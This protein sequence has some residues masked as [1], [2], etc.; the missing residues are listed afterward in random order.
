MR[1][2]DLAELIL[3]V[4]AELGDAMNA[5]VEDDRYGYLL[6]HMQE[7]LAGMFDWPFLKLKGGDADVQIAAGARYA[8][9]PAVNLDREVTVDVQYNNY[10]KCVEYGIGPAEYNLYDSDKQQAMDPIQ[11]WQETDDIVDDG[12]G[13]RTQRFEVWPI[14]TI[15]Q[16]VRFNGQRKLAALEDDQDVADL[17]DVLLILGVATHLA[18]DR[19]NEIK[20]KTLMSRFQNRLEYLKVTSPTRD[21]RLV[22]GQN[23]IRRPNTRKIR[24]MIVLTH[25]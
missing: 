22:L 4:K 25:A 16:V 18:A 12:A 6:S 5:S 24:P 10:W 13:N 23:T 15:N 14:P 1:G 21:E 19:E 11:R 2:K 7:E 17:D 20:A 3:G 8:N 9:L